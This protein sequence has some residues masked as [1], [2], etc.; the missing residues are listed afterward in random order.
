MG[1]FHSVLWNYA[2][3]LPLGRFQ[4]PGNWNDADFIIGGDGG[5]NLA[6]TRSQLALWSMMSAPLILSS[7]LEKL[8]PQA[9][10]ILGNRAILAI[11]Q[12]PLG[13]MATLVRRSPVMDILFKPL[14]GGDYALAVLNRGTAPIRIELASIGFRLCGERRMS[15]SM[16][17]IFG[18]E[19]SNPRHRRCRPAWPPHDTQIWRI[20]AAAACPPPARMGVI[21]MISPENNQDVQS[22]DRYSSV[23]GR[24]GTC[25]GCAG[26]T[27]ETWT[28]TAGGALESGRTLP[29]RRGRQA[30]DAAMCVRED[31]ALE[32]HAVRESGQRR[33]QMS[34]GGGRT[35]GLTMQVCG[36]QSAGPDIGSLPN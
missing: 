28:V 33:T 17:K 7:D 20:H 19:C 36:L 29:G 4:K 2:Y 8:S 13:R 6:E 9:V 23:S 22:I 14:K 3:N 15:V 25:P 1:R 18:A 35:K 5:M 11:D 30:G 16:R 10:A 21:T 24:S 27:A 31:A 26:T 12:D 34:H 32:L